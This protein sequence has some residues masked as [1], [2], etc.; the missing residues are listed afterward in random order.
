MYLCLCL[1]KQTDVQVHMAFIQVALLV[2][3][4]DFVMGYDAET[5]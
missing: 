1:F 5:Y 2:I 4:V 3:Y